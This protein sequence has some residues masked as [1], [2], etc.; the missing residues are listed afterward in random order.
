MPP[1][2]AVSGLG[3]PAAEYRSISLFK[4]LYIMQTWSDF[5]LGCRFLARAEPLGQG[6]FLFGDDVMKDAVG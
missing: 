4:L 6:H 3:R 1:G 5:L 2:A